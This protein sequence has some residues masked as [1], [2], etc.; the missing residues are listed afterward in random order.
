MVDVW[1][2]MEGWSVE[3]VRVVDVALE[4]VVVPVWEESL[5]WMEEVMDGA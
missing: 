3:L 4:M 2:E 5:L 1:R